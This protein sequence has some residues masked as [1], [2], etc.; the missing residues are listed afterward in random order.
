MGT[1]TSVKSPE[2]NEFDK[3]RTSGNGKDADCEEKIGD[4]N[5]KTATIE[6][7]GQKESIQQL[8]TSE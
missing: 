5:A 1:E 8:P 6:K 3:K 2:F 4:S 7:N